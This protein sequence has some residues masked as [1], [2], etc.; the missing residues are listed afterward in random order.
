MAVFIL[1]VNITKTIASINITCS[2][3]LISKTKD[4]VITT[5][6]SKSSCLKVDLL[7]YNHFKARNEFNVAK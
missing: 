4:A 2:L 3:M 5:S 7:S 6:S 1:S